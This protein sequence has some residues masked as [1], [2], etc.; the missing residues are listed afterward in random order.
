MVSTIDDQIEAIKSKAN[1]EWHNHVAPV[2]L[3]GI[4]IEDKFEEFEEFFGLEPDEIAGLMQAQKRRSY[5]PDELEQLL[6]ASRLRLKGG[7]LDKQLR[8]R[9][10]NQFLEIDGVDE[11]HAAVRK[12]REFL[13][14]TN[15]RIESARR[16]IAGLEESLEL[17]K[18][19]VE[20]EGTRH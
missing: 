11:N 7:R 4:V 1:E 2:E 9:I 17:L 19:I 10:I 6:L 20:Q 16:T 13:L 8:E 18:K 12:E 3:Q 15:E 14:S 5:S